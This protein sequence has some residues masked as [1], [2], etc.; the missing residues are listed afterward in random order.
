MN[1]DTP[2]LYL[3]IRL[4]V[5]RLPVQTILGCKKVSCEIREEVEREAA[6]SRREDERVLM[7]FDS[8]EIVSS[9]LR[10]YWLMERRV[11]SLL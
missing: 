1:P 4:L 11:K 9:S 8:L 3:S 5:G 2:K 10:S 7:C 6:V